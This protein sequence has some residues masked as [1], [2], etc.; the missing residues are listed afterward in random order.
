MT[1]KLYDIGFQ[2]SQL[3]ECVFYH[4]DIILITYMDDSLFFGDNDDIL[5][6]IIRKTAG[7]NIE[8]QSY[9]ANYVG[10]NIK[11]SR[12]QTNEFT[13]CALIDAIID[14]ADIDNSYIKTVPA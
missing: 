1:D 5:V 6:L 13:Q 14:H 3:N 9:P 11:N 10:V 12:N 4:D 8:D 2:Q 7:I